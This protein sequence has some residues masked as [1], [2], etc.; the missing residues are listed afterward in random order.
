MINEKLKIKSEFIEKNSSTTSRQAPTNKPSTQ[1]T[2]STSFKPK[3]SY[4]VSIILDIGP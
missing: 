4:N 1:T 3:A 2:I